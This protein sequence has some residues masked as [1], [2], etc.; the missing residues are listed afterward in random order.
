MACA[1]NPHD[2]QTGTSFLHLP[3]GLFSQFLVTKLGI[4]LHPSCNTYWN[5]TTIL[6]MFGLKHTELSVTVI[7]AKAH[8]DGLQPCFSEGFELQCQNQLANFVPQPKKCKFWA[9][10]DILNMALE[11][12]ACSFL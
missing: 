1:W 5:K 11:M 8:Q 9:F 3:E 10:V 6:S 12:M 4:H 2:L 7:T